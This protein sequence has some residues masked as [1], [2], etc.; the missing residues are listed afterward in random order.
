MRILIIHPGALGD[1]LL[2]LPAIK[3]LR[4][5]FSSAIIS[6]IAA[7]Q[8]LPFLEHHGIAD[9]TTSIDG[10][11]MTAL[12]A[13]TLDSG[14]R[15]GDYY[16]AFD[17][18]VGWFSDSGGVITQALH[19]IGVTNVLIQSPRVALNDGKHM[20]QRFFETL[21]DVGV[22]IASSG[23][24]V[25]VTES[26]MEIGVRLLDEQ[27]VAVTGKHVVAIHPGSG[28]ALK[29]WNSRNYVKVIHEVL[30][31]DNS[32]VCIISGPADDDSVSGVMDGFA[33]SFSWR[34]PVLRGLSL[35]EVVGVLGHCRA[36]IGNDSGLTHL[37]AALGVP[38]VA[39]FGPTNP[40]IWGPTGEH[41]R[42]FAGSMPCECLGFNDR[43]ECDQSC[44]PTDAHEIYAALQLCVER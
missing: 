44:F 20:T 22:S 9:S 24:S 31:A 26:E 38:T 1:L 34:L 6:V 35:L 23:Q 39:V 40:E 8:L 43:S 19:L 12:Y 30:S 11:A 10:Q 27:G 21:Q 17:L 13:N 25:S 3:S 32:L 33:S 14:T 5:K 28:S 42:C 16:S 4:A 15:W 18:V 41:V 29:N 37:S 36:Y 7:P 2:A